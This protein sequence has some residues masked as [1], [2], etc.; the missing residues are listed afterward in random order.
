MNHD[1][2]DETLPRRA[3]TD[4]FDIKFPFA[5]DIRIEIIQ[6]AV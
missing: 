1:S 5:T 6:P 3:M 4:S 2:R